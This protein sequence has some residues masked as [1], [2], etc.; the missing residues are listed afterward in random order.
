[1]NRN[2]W[3]KMF[4]ASVVVSLASAC[5]LQPAFPGLRQDAALRPSALGKL[6]GS[7]ATVAR[8]LHVLPDERD[9][10]FLGAIA[11]ATKAVKLQ[12]YML[13][14][15]GVIDGLVKAHRRGVQVQV[16]LEEKP[17]NPGN[18][19]KPLPTN[20]AA[21]NTLVA[22]GVPVRWT[23]P[24]FR[25]THAKVVTLDDTVSYVSTANFTKSGL[26]ASGKGARE[27][28]VEDRVP[29][30]VSEFV[31][32][33]AADWDRQPYTPL[34]D[35]LVVSP[36]NSREKIFNL[37]RSARKEI[38]VQVEVAGDPDLDALLAEK[39]RQGVRVR[40]LLADLRRLQAE[41]DP[42]LR[43]N[44]D[45]A[46]TW[47][48]SGVEVLF[49]KVP[50]LH[51]KAVQVDGGRFYVGSVNLTTNSLNNNR[52]LGLLLDTPALATRIYR[53]MQ[54][55]FARA[56][57]IPSAVYTLESHRGFFRLPAFTF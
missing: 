36:T 22:A 47:R 56:Q 31:A 18:P 17:Y 33:F 50:H 53:V 30:D 27:Y 11:R 28:I 6:M 4:A 32:M 7:G 16:L 5:V 13:T 3:C 26:N 39:V 51:A 49:Q 23:D 12:V 29:R 52:E 2:P 1:M 9:T 25:F 41:D 34:G 55:D 44:L 19:N 54:A 15:P 45:V 37:I 57:P 10:F 46:R 38:F 20:R 43:A 42:A 40:A 21:F 8:V 35:D 24:T 14:H 48:E